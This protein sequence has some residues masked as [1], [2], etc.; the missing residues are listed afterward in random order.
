M[1]VRII[2]IHVMFNNKLFMLINTDF[3]VE[4]QQHEM[5]VFR[6]IALRVGYHLSF[7]LHSQCFYVIELCIDK[8]IGVNILF[9]HFLFFFSSKAFSSNGK[10]G[11]Q[12]WS[13]DVPV[14]T[15]RSSLHCVRPRFHAMPI[16]LPA[17]QGWVPQTHGNF[18]RSLA[19]WYGVQQVWICYI[20]KKKKKN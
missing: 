19:R 7:T 14:C 15:I 20:K 9:M 10:P 18:W 6:G 1:C 11:V 17:G 12:C 13:E 3:S 8:N 4:Y 16:P 5:S 2:H